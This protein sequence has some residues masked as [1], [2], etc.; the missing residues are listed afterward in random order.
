MPHVE[1]K[2]Y[3]S[4][5]RSTSESSTSGDV[6]GGEPEWDDDASSTVAGIGRRGGR[7]TRDDEDDVADNN[8]TDSGAG[9]V[10][11]SS[12]VGDASAVD[13]V[14][15]LP[16]ACADALTGNVFSG[17][18]SGAPNFSAPVDGV[19][20]ND[21]GAF[22][23]PSQWSCVCSAN[24]SLN[25]L[26]SARGRGSARPKAVGLVCKCDGHESS[27]GS[28]LGVRISRF[29]AGLARE[30][31][32]A[33]GLGGPPNVSISSSSIARPRKGFTGGSM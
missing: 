14:V 12:A 10:A 13:S 9:D 6:A 27:L 32:P 30:V 15:G 29:G 17:V 2:P 11:W 19:G 7:F 24:R 5:M 21:V 28:R 22:H 18:G 20:V 26:C 16:P 8:G 3:G 23:A 33:L 1:S 25:V 4:S 31:R